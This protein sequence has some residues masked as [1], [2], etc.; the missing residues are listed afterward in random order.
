MQDANSD[1][2]RRHCALSQ[3]RL[4][5][6]ADCIDECSFSR[7]LLEVL[8]ATA[9]ILELSVKLEELSVATTFCRGFNRHSM[10]SHSKVAMTQPMK[11]PA[12]LVAQCE[13]P[14]AAVSDQP[15]LPDSLQ[16]KAFA[17]AE[18]SKG[19]RSRSM[20]QEDKRKILTRET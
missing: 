12:G 8:L 10:P 2:R 1:F 11:R 13:Q 4:V 17:R 7:H 20:R 6:G 16:A 5:L 19:R 15:S 14:D 3:A 18:R 9:R